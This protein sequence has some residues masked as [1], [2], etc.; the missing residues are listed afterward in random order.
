MYISAIYVYCAFATAGV[1]IDS[2]RYYRLSRYRSLFRKQPASIWR[3]PTG[4]Q[5]LLSI[6]VTVR[7]VDI[8]N[9]RYLFEIDNYRYHF[10]IIHVQP[11]RDANGTNIYAALYSF[12][13][14]AVFWMKVRWRTFSSKS[15]VSLLRHRK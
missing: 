5:Y 1:S 3:D 14:I 13:Q 12:S 2:C 9:Y 6:S 15:F 11:F 10:E 7:P 4:D 8:D